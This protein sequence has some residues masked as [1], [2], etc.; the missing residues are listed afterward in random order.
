MKKSKYTKTEV[1][2]FAIEYSLRQLS[3]ILQN[4]VPICDF[5]QGQINLLLDSYLERK[6]IIK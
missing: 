3:Q 4:N 2:I 5:L 6:P 1:E